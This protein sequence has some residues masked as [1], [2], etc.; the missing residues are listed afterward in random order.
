[1]SGEE[2]GYPAD[3][4]HSTGCEPK[5]FDKVNSVDGD[6]T[7]INDPNRDNISEFSKTT[8]ESIGLFGVP[9]VFEASVS[10]VSHGDF[11]LQ[12]ESKE[13]MLRETVAR[14]RETKEKVL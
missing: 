13:S 2:F 14:Q 9:T 11:A 1:M 10:Q 8:R 3:S 7:P 6:T 12:K 5:E 4:T